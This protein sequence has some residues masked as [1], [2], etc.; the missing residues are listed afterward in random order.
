MALECVFSESFKHSLIECILGGTPFGAPSPFDQSTRRLSPSGRFHWSRSPLPILKGTSK[1][2]KWS[3]F[4]FEFAT[5]SSDPVKMDHQAESEEN[6]SVCI[7]I[8]PLNDREKRNKDAHVLRCLPRLNAL[9][10]TDRQNQPLPGA[11]NVFQYDQIFPPD[12]TTRDIYDTVGRRIVDSTLK[13]INGTIFA[14]GQ[15]SSGKVLSFRIYIYIYI[16]IE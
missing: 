16:D 14:Y 6:I 5:S 9:S 4:I 15:T 2:S 13:G 1:L 7:R 11:N 3:M 12:V 8:R 10:I